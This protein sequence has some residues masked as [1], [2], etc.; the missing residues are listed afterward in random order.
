MTVGT[1]E[2][3]I[4]E[5]LSRPRPRHRPFAFQASVFHVQRFGPFPALHQHR[6][7]GFLPLSLH[8]TLVW[9]GQ[10]LSLREVLS[11]VAETLHGCDVKQLGVR[12]VSRGCSSNFL[13]W[14]PAAEPGAVLLSRETLWETRVGGRG[15]GGGPRSCHVL[16]RESYPNAS[17][18]VPHGPQRA[19]RT[20]APRAVH[21]ADAI[22]VKGR[23]RRVATAQMSP[24][25]PA[26]R[27][28]SRSQPTA[29]SVMPFAEN[30]QPSPVRG[31]RKQMGGG[32]GQWGVP[33]ERGVCL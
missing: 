8:V 33:S 23:R 28:K 29:G 16:L 26:R 14:P 17:R 21:P 19:A 12:P 25:S 7:P 5:N 6:P 4:S 22:R 31:D 2:G 24:D 3:H 30:V 9:P 32:W 11:H 15:R 13:D 10:L 1:R 18:Q 27:E 20:S